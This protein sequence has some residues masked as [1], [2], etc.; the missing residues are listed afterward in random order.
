MEHK[1]Y[2]RMGQSK[3]A[4]LMLHG[5]CGTPAHFRALIPVIPEDVSVYALLLDGHGGSVADFSHTSMKKWKAQVAG[6]LGQLYEKYKKILIVGHS[7]G[8]LFAI[9]A[10]TERPDKVAGLFLLAVPTRPWVRLSTVATCLRAIRK[11]PDPKDRPVQVLLE[12]TS[13]RLEPYFWKYIPWAP[14]MIELLQ[15]CRRVR[16]LLPRLQVQ[17]LTFQSQVDELVDFRSCRDLEGHPYIQNTVLPGSGHFAYSPEDT[18]LLQKQL[19]EL[20]KKA[21][22]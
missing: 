16:K 14:R 2:I 8:T 4:V 13:I 5:I 10:A 12:D 19:A 3:Y 1:E 21:F 15:E 7:M 6:V 22:P 20:L 9:R 11:H 17:A 18:A